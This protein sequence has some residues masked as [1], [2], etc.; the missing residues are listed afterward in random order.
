MATMSNPPTD[1]KKWFEITTIKIDENLTGNCV[2]DDGMVLGK[3]AGPSRSTANLFHE[4]AHFIEIDDRRCLK[5]AWGLK[6]PSIYIGGR[7]CY[8]PE[9]FQASEREMRVIAIQKIIADHL[10]KRCQ[11]RSFARAL[12]FM[13]D[14]YMAGKFFDKEKE[15]DEIEYNKYKNLI[16]N[17]RINWVL[18]YAEKLNINKIWQEWR[19]KCNIHDQHFPDGHKNPKADIVI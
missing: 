11:L 2:Y 15:L 9:T 10:G 8:E 3:M 19:S 7:T 16:I 17:E 14:Y 1:L 12:D 18:S 5:T 6:V 4:M 13:P